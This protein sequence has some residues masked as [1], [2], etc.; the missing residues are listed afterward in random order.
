MSVICR[1]KNSQDGIFELVVARELVAF[2][3]GKY[4]S[5]TAK[6]VCWG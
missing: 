2:R 6:E 5:H 4:L 3:F 1:M